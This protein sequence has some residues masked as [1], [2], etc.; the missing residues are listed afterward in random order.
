MLLKL[1]KHYGKHNAGE[2]AEFAD[3]TA[4]FL[5]SRRNSDGVPDPAARKLTKD[6]REGIDKAHAEAK[7]KRAA[8]IDKH[9][10][11]MQA[12]HELRAQEAD[13]KPAVRQ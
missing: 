5:L 6:E 3:D 13:L 7:D 11:Q 4:N 9:R 10:K 2:I 8:L 12:D 1:L